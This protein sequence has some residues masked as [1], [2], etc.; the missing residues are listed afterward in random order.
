MKMLKSVL[1]LPLIFGFTFI[2]NAQ[3]GEVDTNLQWPAG[4]CGYFGESCLPFEQTQLYD[5]HYSPK[6]LLEKCLSSYFLN[7][8]VK[9]KCIENYNEAIKN[10]KVSSF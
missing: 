1:L 3:T 5:R 2:V 8:Q 4:V 7:N 9:S 6:A 10:D